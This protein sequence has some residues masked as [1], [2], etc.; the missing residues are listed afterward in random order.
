MPTLPLAQQ[1]S[2]V[3]MNPK[4]L[5]KLADDLQRWHDWVRQMGY[6]CTAED[7]E[8]FPSIIRLSKTWSSYRGL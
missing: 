5:D 8:G 1:P 6:L 2:E 3:Y 7:I 4:D